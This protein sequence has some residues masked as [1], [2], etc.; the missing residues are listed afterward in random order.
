MNDK[1]EESVII[2][3]IVGCIFLLI[4][5]VCSFL[6]IP[7]IN[8]HYEDLRVPLVIDII[9]Q[10]AVLYP[11]LLA[12]DNEFSLGDGKITLAN[13]LYEVEESME[14]AY[15]QDT[16][17]GESAKSIKPKVK[18]AISEGSYKISP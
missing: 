9:E 11:H 16:S 1:N 18:I 3:L 4:F 15:G 6:F 2:P 8:N 14:N 5:T 12:E 17:N 10:H 7:K 13:S